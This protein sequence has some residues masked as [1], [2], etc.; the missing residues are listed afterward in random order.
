MKIAKR[1][2]FEGKPIIHTPSVFGASVGKAFMYRIPVTGER[3]VTITMTTDRTDLR[4]ENARNL[5]AAGVP[6]ATAA[7]ESGFAD[8]KYFSRVVKLKYQ[9]TPKDLKNFGK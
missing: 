1:Q 6:V 5:I 9:C 8:P 3:P 7:E 4:L 2:P